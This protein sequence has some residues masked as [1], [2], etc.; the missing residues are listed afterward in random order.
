MSQALSNKSHFCSKFLL[1]FVSVFLS[2]HPPPLFVDNQQRALALLQTRPIPAPPQ[3]HPYII[4]RAPPALG[5]SRGDGHEVR[6]GFPR[7]EER[8]NVRV[9]ARGCAH[10]RACRT[11]LG[12]KLYPHRPQNSR[13][14]TS[15]T[16]HQVDFLEFFFGTQP[17]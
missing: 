7:R 13:T 11:P 15:A 14:P 3:N 6:E 10:A 8:E 12:L 9:R 2:S 16:Q 17:S 5:S 4:P 1:I